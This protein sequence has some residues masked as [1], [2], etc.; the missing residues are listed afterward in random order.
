VT[1]KGKDYININD[2]VDTFKSPWE[3]PVEVNG[4]DGV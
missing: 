4:T 3:T 2:T 1:I